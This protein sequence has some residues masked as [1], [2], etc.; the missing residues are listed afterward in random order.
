[1]TVY[2]PTSRRIVFAVCRWVVAHRSSACSLHT[3][4]SPHAPGVMRLLAAGKPPKVALTAVMHKLLH[5]LNAV[6]RDHT[7]WAPRPA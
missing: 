4:V 3:D 2:L 7:P 5:I 1:M 6:V